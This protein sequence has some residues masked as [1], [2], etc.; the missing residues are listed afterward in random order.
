MNSAYNIFKRILSDT[1]HT[2]A[3]YN[4]LDQVVNPPIDYSDLLRWQWA[5]ACSAL[6]KL[7]HDL[8][9]AG[10]L[11]IFSGQRQHTSKYLSFTLTLDAHSQMTINQSI[12]I[13]V[14]D[15][16]I[17]MK[18]GYLTFQE[19]DKI[20]D[21]LSNIWGEKHKWQYVA[22]EM[23]L[24]E[25]FIKTKLRNISIRRNQIVH[26]GDYSSSLLQRQVITY[27]DVQDVLSFVEKLG[28]AIYKLVK[29]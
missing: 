14:L 26:E 23:G 6:D 18:H 19:P 5:Q 28:S 25:D 17:S 3:V 29:L 4:Y 8:V 27:A 11:E 9:K 24:A 15:Q 13:Q 21:A 7:V 2:N 20:S 22:T 10:M 1:Q 12:A 16:Q